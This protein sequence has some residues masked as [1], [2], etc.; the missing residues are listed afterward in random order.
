MSK[1]YWGFSSW[2][3]HS[4]E[5]LVHTVFFETSLC[6]HRILDYIIISL[7]VMRALHFVK[8]FHTPTLVVYSTRFT[9]II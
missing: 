7:Q 3:L 4:Y 2:S 1:I 5:S 8:C 6:F 9:V